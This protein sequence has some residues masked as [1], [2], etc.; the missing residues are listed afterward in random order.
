MHV[1]PTTTRR[2]EPA[3]ACSKAFATVGVVICVV[4]AVA[5]GSGAATPGR[6]SSA[7]DAAPI[8]SRVAS[9]TDRPA[10]QP[11]VA[12]NAPSSSDGLGQSPAP[13]SR[14]ASSMS[15]KPAPSS[16]VEPGT[17]Q[18]P[19]P[20]LRAGLLAVTVTDRLRVRSRPGVG[21]ESAKYE[22][23][24]SLGTRMSIIE[25]PVAGSGYWWYRVKA[26]DP[27]RNLVRGA[28]DGWVAASDH[29][30]TPWVGPAP[31]TCERFAFT[32]R[33]ISA[34]SFTELATGMTGNWAGCVTQEWVPAYWVWIT[35]GQDGTYR[36][37]SQPNQA[38]TWQPAF[39]YGTDDDSPEKRYQL[40][41]FQDSLRGVGQIDIVFWP[42][43]TNRGDLR[44]ISLMDDQL[45]FEFFH[46]GEYGPFTYRLYSVDR[47]S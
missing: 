18:A 40:N 20:G 46:R 28:Q 24:L 36:A 1:A 16:N 38:A 26:A 31:D 19:R 41:D 35:F 23:L 2:V 11:A 29:D 39:Y 4:S 17:V 47:P 22:P 44:N 12:S 8:D 32:T 10:S 13:S 34:G 3:K 42:G 37:R 30:G 45:E 43:N 21:T 27:D 15:P 33:A 25:G 7:S 5:C 14:A 9:A 6:N